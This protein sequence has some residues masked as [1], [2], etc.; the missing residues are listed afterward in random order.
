MATTNKGLEKLK[1]INTRA[2]QIRTA[3]GSTKQTITVVKFKIKQKDAVKQ[4][5]R[6]LRGVTVKAHK[7]IRMK[8]KK[9]VQLRLFK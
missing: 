2:K 1:K 3:G 9:S 7:R 4:A 5:A 8:K 6:E